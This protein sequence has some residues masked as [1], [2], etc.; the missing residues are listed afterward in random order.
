TTTATA[1]GCRTNSRVTVPPS[2]RSTSSVTRSNTLPACSTPADVV[3]SW[4]DSSRSRS[5]IGA[6]VCRRRHL[7]QA[8]LP[9]TIQ[10]RPHEPLEQRVGP[11]RTRLELRVRLR[12]HVV[13]VLLAVELHELHERGVGR[14]AGD[15]Q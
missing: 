13:R 12:G 7:E 9:L 4:A 2:P 5:V 11:G 1:P 3:G 14:T 10:R 15:L 8:R 6:L